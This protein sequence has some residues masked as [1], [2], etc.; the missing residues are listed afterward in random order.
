MLR[1]VSA[2]RLTNCENE[3]YRSSRLDDL[4]A[5]RTSLDGEPV[6]YV[7]ENSACQEPA[8]G[9]AAIVAALDKLG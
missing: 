4:F 1:A 6:L 7:C 9:L 5:G 8:V 3:Q 2:T